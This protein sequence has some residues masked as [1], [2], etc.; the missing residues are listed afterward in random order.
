[1][2]GNGRREDCETMVWEHRN[3][4]LCPDGV[5]AAGYLGGAVLN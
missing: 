2:M 3:K 5:L 4:N 1:M